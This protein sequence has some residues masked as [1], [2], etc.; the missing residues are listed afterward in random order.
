[1][2]V[3]QRAA[4]AEDLAVDSVGVQAAIDRVARNQADGGGAG[5]ENPAHPRVVVLGQPEPDK[6]ALAPGAAAV[7]GGIDAARVRPLARVAERFVVVAHDVPGRVQRPDLDA[8]AVADLALLGDL[9]AVVLLPL[10]EPGQV[11]LGGL[12][13]NECLG[14]SGCVAAAQSRSGCCRARSASSPTN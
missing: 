10:L 2:A 5:I 11:H 7:H 14:S 4:G 13:H 9:L 6:L 8:G 1:D 3:D 12:V